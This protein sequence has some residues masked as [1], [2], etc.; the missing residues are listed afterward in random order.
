MPEMMCAA[1]AECPLMAAP[2]MA[3]TPVMTVQ[4]FGESAAMHF[5]CSALQS[6][7]Q[8]KQSSDALFADAHGNSSLQQQTQQP[9][10]YLASLV[11]S[12]SGV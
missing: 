9:R 8:P 6:G 3:N 4:W 1:F 5:I 10:Q 11:Q 2:L 7:C 12:N